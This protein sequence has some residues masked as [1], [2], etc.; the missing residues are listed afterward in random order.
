M[1]LVQFC[2][3][4]NQLGEHIMAFEIINYI[5]IV[6]IAFVLGGL[7]D[8]EHSCEVAERDWIKMMPTWWALQ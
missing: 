5:Q 6:K 1:A 4:W 3:F 8:Y 2:I 7:N